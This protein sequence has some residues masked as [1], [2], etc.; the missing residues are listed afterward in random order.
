M[1]L[2]LCVPARFP[3]SSLPMPYCNQHRFAFLLSS[4]RRS[5]NSGYST[6]MS[7]DDEPIDL[8]E[9]SPMKSGAS[10]LPVPSNLILF[11][12]LVYPASALSASSR[13]ASA[14]PSMLFQA[15][16][17]LTL[18]LSSFLGKTKA[19]GSRNALDLALALVKSEPESRKRRG[20]IPC[21]HQYHPVTY[22]FSPLCYPCFQSLIPAPI[23]AYEDDD[24]DWQREVFLLK[25]VRTVLAHLILDLHSAC[26]HF[27]AFHL[28]HVF[29]FLI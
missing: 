22:P 20:V 8:T 7:D 5:R 28:S 29:I 19:P 2:C 10:Y 23:Q 25:F 18:H 16:P 15:E 3:C 26:L 6:R 24:P 1:S 14:N 4:Q 13:P 17:Q 11:L 21:C 12:F 27:V 9:D